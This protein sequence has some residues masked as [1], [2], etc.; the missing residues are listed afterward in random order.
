MTERWALRAGLAVVLA[1]AI[2]AP[3]AIAT[4]RRDTPP[5]D[6]AIKALLAEHGARILR[7]RSLGAESEAIEASFP[8]CKAPVEIFVASSALED[9]PKFDGAQQGLTAFVYLGETHAHLDHAQ[10]WFDYLSALGQNLIRARP[11]ANLDEVVALASRARCA[12]V[13]A[14]NWTPIWDRI[15]AKVPSAAP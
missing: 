2:S 14:I 13:A 10:L 5:V 1:A 15:D 3:A 7:A 8:A 11:L 6:I 12:A 9:R 4:W